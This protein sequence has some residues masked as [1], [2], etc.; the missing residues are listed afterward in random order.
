MKTQRV[1]TAL[2]L[3]ISLWAVA[4]C[5]G[6]SSTATTSSA[7]TAPAADATTPDLGGPAGGPGGMSQPPMMAQTSGAKQ[8]MAGGNGGGVKPAGK[9]LTSWD[10][11][12]KSYVGAPTDAGGAGVMAGPGGKPKPIVEGIAAAK[13]RKDPFES[14]FK[15]TTLLS[16]SLFAVTHRTAPDLILTPSTPAPTGDPSFDLPPLPFEPRRIAGVMYNGAIAAILEV[17]TPPNSITTIVLPGTEVRP[18]PG[19]MNGVTL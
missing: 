12:P 19:V 5:G 17:G 10:G 15:P 18:S 6:D 11:A 13:A 1:L 4:G 16:P 9:L 3:V 7:S 8:M 2:T 14:L